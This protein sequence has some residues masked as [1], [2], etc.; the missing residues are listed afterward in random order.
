MVSLILIKNVYEVLGLQ[1]TLRAWDVFLV[2]DALGA[3][4]VPI[5]AVEAVDAGVKRLLNDELLENYVTGSTLL[6]DV[7]DQDMLVEVG[8]SLRL[9]WPVKILQYVLWREDTFTFG[10][11][12]CFFV[13]ICVMG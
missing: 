10:W 7:R 11:P 3:I 13:L 1:G 8:A 6:N 2:E 5:V 4:D 12:L 9:A